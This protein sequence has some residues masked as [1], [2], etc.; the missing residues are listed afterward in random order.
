MNLTIENILLIGSLLLLVSIFAGKTSYKFGVPTLLLFLAIGMLAGSDGIGGIRFNDPQLAQFIGIVSLNFILFSGGL[1]TNWTAVKPILREGILLSTL[2]VL[3]TAVSL[4]TFVYY[5][6]DFTIYE[7]LLLGSIV[8]S[9]DAAAVFSILRSKSLALKTNL[10]PTLELESG[11]N[12]PMAYVLT[13]AFLTL[14]IN[15]DQSFASIVPLFFQQMILGGIAGIAFGISSKFIINKIKLDFEGLYPV[16]VIA[17][18]FTTFSAT[19]FIG[20]N[21][22][23]AIY[24]CAV[25]LGNQNLIHKKTILKMFDGLAWLMQIV[26]FLTLGLLVF[27]SQIIPYMG[28]GLLISVFLILVARPIGVFISLMFFKMKLKRRFYISWVGL[29]GAVPIV[30]ATY[31]LLAGI[32]K[33][34]MIF[35]IVFFISV[36]SILIQGTTLSLVAKWL[37]VGLPETQKK[38]TTSDLLLAEN[39]KAEMKEFLITPDC[40]AVDKKIVQL[41]FPKNAIIAMIKRDVSY[42]IP[43]GL[44]KIKVHDTLIVL[45]DNPK[46]FDEVYKTLEIQKAS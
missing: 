45:A 39:P 10:R 31:P 6:T 43:N 36:T 1:D 30:F 25:Y 20:G 34:N 38:S 15:Q 7:S 22:F 27:P 5:V 18:M 35:N 33:A 9:T 42:I 41:G 17:L 12:D 3:L 44:T 29:R 11:S 32:D 16:L 2:G 23:L 19:N 8:S 13:I 26:L 46:V 24:I 37:N 4:G 40:A 21:G 28:I 14:V